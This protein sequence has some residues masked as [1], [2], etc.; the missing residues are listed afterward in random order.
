MKNLI[1]V[2][3][4]A[5]LLV[6]CSS[7]SKVGNIGGVDIYEVNTR[8]FLSPMS[9]TVITHDPENGEVA[10]ING[11]IGSSGLGQVA[12]PAATVGSA[13]LIKEGLRKSGDEITDNTSNTTVSGAAAVNTQ[14]QGQ[15]QGQA[16]GQAQGQFITNKKSLF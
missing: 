15:V 6:S 5:M 2:L 16:Q 14:V 3:I 10:K 11:G 12:G 9:T 13:Y 4:V 7:I 8:D 1:V